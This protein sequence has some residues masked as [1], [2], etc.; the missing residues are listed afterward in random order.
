[1]RLNASQGMRPRSA[2]GIAVSVKQCRDCDLIF[3]DPL[4]IPASLTDHYGVPPE[5][6]WTSEGS[7]EWSPG[8]FAHEIETAK[9]LLPFRKGMKALD[10]GV[11]LG[12]GM[13]SLA[14]AGFD[15]WGIEPSEPFYERAAQKLDRDRLQLAAVEDAEFPAESFDFITF[16]AVL[17]HIYDPS[18]ALSRVLS[19]LKPGG[20]IQA[21]VPS[22]AHLMARLINRY[23]R[24]RGTN[25]V[26][27]ISPMHTPFHLYEF[28]LKSFQKNAQLSGYELA[29]HRFTVCSIYHVPRLLHPPLRWWMERTN[30][31][32]QLTVYLRKPAGAPREEAA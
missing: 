15:V 18:A 25:Y 17:E 27:H 32:M 16:G 31:G 9:R 1:M 3:A 14:H 11:G 21:E 24:L 12:L 4:P 28:G 29:D 5:E 2:E 7:G 22:S 20:I 30:S 10:V 8:Y 19:W 13:R 6:Y 26:T 23:F